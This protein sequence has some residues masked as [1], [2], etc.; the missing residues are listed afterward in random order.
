MGVSSII[1]RATFAAILAIQ[2]AGCTPGT[3]TPSSNSGSNQTPVA[4]AGPTQ[5]VSLGALVQLDGSASTVGAQN[6]ISF[7]WSL[8]AKPAGSGATLSS[9]TAVKPTFIADVAGDYVAQLKVSDGTA[10]SPVASTTIVASAA[11]SVPVANAGADQRV[12]A[13]LGTTANVNLNGGQSSDADGDALRYDWTLRTRPAGSQSALVDAKTQAP[14]FVADSAG[15]YEIDLV[16]SDGQ[17]NST[18]DT[19]VVTAERPNT[20]PIASAG[21]DQAVQTGARVQLNGSASSDANGDPLTYAWRFTQRPSGSGAAL[22]STTV[23][24]PTFTPDLD[25]DFILELVVNDGFVSSSPDNVVV[26]STPAPR[27]P[28]AIWTPSATNVCSNISGNGSGSDGGGLPITGYGWTLQAE[29][30]ANSAAG[31]PRSLGTNQSFSIT[32]NLAGTYTIELVV[33]TSLGSSPANSQSVTIAGIAEGLTSFTN[34]SCGVGSGCHGGPSPSRFVN[35]PYSYEYVRDRISTLGTAVGH[36][37]GNGFGFN[38][39]Q[40]K[41][42]ASYLNSR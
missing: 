39:C 6:A 36:T 22:T 18:V 10:L 32:P 35:R 40:V 30:A 37:G 31:I 16:V 17:R 20:A 21:P 13:G 29:P 5:N 8:T 34:A 12:S 4:V 3:E 19:I 14:R 42:I 38:I 26:R 11:N 33:S 28:T 2:I 41:Q 27:L 25:G 7:I 24:S 1:F 9:S 23:A 15:V